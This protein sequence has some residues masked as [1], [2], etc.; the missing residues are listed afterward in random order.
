[1]G[2]LNKEKNHEMVVANEAC[3]TEWEIQEP[4]KTNLARVK[5][6]QKIDKGQYAGSIKQARV[7]ILILM[8]HGLFPPPPQISVLRIF[9]PDIEE[10][11]L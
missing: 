9:L 4:T 6:L 7:T 2:G 8:Q 5:K 1:M 11:K 3:K 10:W